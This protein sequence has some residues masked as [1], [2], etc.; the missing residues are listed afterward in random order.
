MMING[1]V[2]VRASEITNQ[3]IKKVYSLIRLFVYD[4]STNQRIKH[5]AH[6]RVMST[7][8]PIP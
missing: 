6:S 2:E 7:L 8:L 3:R 5:Q 4:Q 1:L